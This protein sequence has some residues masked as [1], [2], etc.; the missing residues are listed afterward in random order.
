MLDG[1]PRE[2]V[3][4]LVKEGC[5]SPAGLAD[6]EAVGALIED[7]IKKCHAFYA[8][9]PEWCGPTDIDHVAGA[10]AASEYLSDR[11]QMLHDT[12]TR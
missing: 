2:M 10:L 3:R 5:L 6:E 11:G 12:D 8:E 9:H 4:T 7:A 1:T